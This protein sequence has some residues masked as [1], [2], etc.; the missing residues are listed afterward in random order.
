VPAVQ[1]PAPANALDRLVLTLFRVRAEEGDLDAEMKLSD[2]HDAAVQKE[3]VLLATTPP[4]D[5][6]EKAVLSEAHISAGG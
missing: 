4:A 2:M 1:V 6:P 5:K 3:L